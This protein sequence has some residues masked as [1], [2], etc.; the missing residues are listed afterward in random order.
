MKGSERLKELWPNNLW[1]PFLA[2]LYIGVVIY[3]F[4]LF[5][6]AGNKLT[7]AVGIGALSSSACIVFGT[8]SNKAAHVKN[9]IGAYIIALA[10]GL[11]MHLVSLHFKPSS[12]V[13]FCNIH[14][15][16]VTIV[17]GL[18]MLVM[19][20][21]D[22]FHPPAVGLSIVVI[23]DTCSYT[24]AWIILSAAALLACLR[25]ALR[26]YLRDIF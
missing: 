14:D 24:S 26:S 10:F 22:L 17:I 16:W 3:V 20:A 19:S 23:L 25:L 5:I 2:A 4:E 7:W 8:P 9:L 11:T 1:Q 13:Q 18:S 15:I 6:G 21:L 12:L